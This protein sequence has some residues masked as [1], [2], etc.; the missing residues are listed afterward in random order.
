MDINKTR[1]EIIILLRE[2]PELQ[3]DDILR[4]DMI[5]GQTDAFDLVRLLL[6]Q[7]RWARAHCTGIAE[8]IK[9]YKLTLD[10]AEMHE[11]RI[12]KALMTIMDTAGLKKLPPFPEGTVFIAAGRPKVIITDEA[13]LPLQYIRVKE[14][15]DREAIGEALRGGT[16]VPGATLS[17]S[18]PAITI[19]TK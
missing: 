7:I 9:E 10:R 13:Q 11:P 2:H 14:E 15:P 3:E 8:L 18:E 5:E 19:R 12:K 17:N 4:A 16:E 1:N 6:R